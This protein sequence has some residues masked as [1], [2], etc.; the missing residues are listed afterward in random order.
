MSRLFSRW[1]IGLAAI[2]TLALALV[3]PMATGSS[4]ALAQGSSATISP[5]QGPVGTQVTAT[6]TGWTAGDHIQAI[7][8]GGNGPDVGSPVVVNSGGG[9]TLT[10]SVPSS[11]TTG[12]SYQVA[13]ED[14][15]QRYFEVANQN[16][17]VTSQ[18][19]GLPTAPY[20]VKVVPYGPLDFL[21]TWSDNATTF[22]QPF[23]VYNGVTTQAVTNTPPNQ[24]VWHV[25]QP[26]TYMCFAVRAYNSSGYSAWAGMWTCA[27]TP[28]GGAPAAPTNVTAT[29]ISTTAIKISF[30]NQA[31]NETAF[32]F[33]NGVST[34]VY[35]SYSEPAKGSSFSV[36][37]TGLQPHTW[38][39]FQVAAYNE[40][41][42]S[43]Y[44]PSTWACAY[45]QG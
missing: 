43:S 7:W 23:Q 27:T 22:G 25:S 19:S 28:A 38:M 6:G 8:N 13:F 40:W 39:C 4:P 5:A 26:N 37:W 42:R 45:T 17:T 35:N 11:A 44:V 18:P 9:F 1:H 30:V 14:T 29:G 16:F 33:Y 32:L 20:N 3:I 2:S 41:G 24:Y 36:A 12:D 31:N 21:V 34:A 10:F 15:D